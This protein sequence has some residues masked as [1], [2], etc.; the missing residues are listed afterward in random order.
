M[1]NIIIK[2]LQSIKKFSTESLPDRTKIFLSALW[3]W[4]YILYY[5]T[6]IINIF[7]SCIITYT[8][9]SCIIFK[10]K[11]IK[12]KDTPIII[13]AKKYKKKPG[14]KSQDT[15]NNDATDITTANINTTSQDMEDITNKISTLFN[16]IWDKT[17]EDN[18][19]VHIKD[20]ISK[21]KAL[22][23]SY[24]WIVYM[25]NIDETIENLDNAEIKQ[26]INHMLIDFS[27]RV[28]YRNNDMK[29]PEDI[30]FGE[31]PF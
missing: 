13:E 12:N 18:G 3:F 31:V 2:K 23:S 29:T 9:D 19:G 25:F 20:I 27:D 4:T 10:T 16:W 26:K 11:A 15:T 30:I 14:V 7:L 6:K 5:F 17:I 22:S 28:I 24:L 8:P 1:T 21:Y